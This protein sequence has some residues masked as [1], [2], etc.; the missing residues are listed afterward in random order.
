MRRAIEVTDRLKRLQR[1]Q[2]LLFPVEQR[3]DPVSEGEQEHQ[4]LPGLIADFQADE[5]AVLTSFLQNLLQTLAAG[6]IM[7][8]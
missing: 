7:I 2:D 8:N 6:E 1:D 5:V 3:S 4:H